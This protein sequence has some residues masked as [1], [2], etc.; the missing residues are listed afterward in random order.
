MV[1]YSFE[2][3][4]NL[5]GRT[6][7]VHGS[8]GGCLGLVQHLGDWWYASPVVKNSTRSLTHPSGGPSRSF[9][10]HPEAVQWLQGVRD[11]QSDWF[12]QA[13]SDVT[14]VGV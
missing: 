12:A 8:R 13:M 3:V 1:S 7:A 11:A 6:L 5:P 10:S 9:K 2:L 4:S 14:K